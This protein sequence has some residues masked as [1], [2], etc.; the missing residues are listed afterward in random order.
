MSEGLRAALQLQRLALQAH[1]PDSFNHYHRRAK[2]V[3][4]AE[5]WPLGYLYFQTGET[6]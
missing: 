6:L 3:A 2:A 1:D 5:D 4:A